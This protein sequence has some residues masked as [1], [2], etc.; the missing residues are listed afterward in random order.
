[1]SEQLVVV[2]SGMAAT[3]LV[4]ELLA[5]GYAGEISVFGDEPVAP[6][7]RILLSAL[8]E[9]THAPSAITLRETEWFAANG[10]NLHLG[11]RV[12]DVDRAR[13]EVM[14][15]DGTRFGYDRLVLATGSIP[16]LPPIRGLVRMDG[17]LH[18]AVHAFRSVADCDR[19][20]A[21]MS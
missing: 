16:T 20:L 21:A 11:S 5:R 9:G 12:L 10:V 13:R 6:Y 15:V 18:P 2:G 1:M 8:I 7:N 14:L 4:E 19:L 17:S 3:R